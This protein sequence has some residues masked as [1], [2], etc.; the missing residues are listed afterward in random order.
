[1]GKRTMRRDMARDLHHV[2]VPGDLEAIADFLIS[3]RGWTNEAALTTDGGATTSALQ[4]A[5]R[6]MIQDDAPDAVRIAITGF[7]ADGAPV[8]GNAARTAAQRIAE[9][10]IRQEGA[11]RADPR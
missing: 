5:L 11:R 9:S 3:R 4:P 7:T 2:G 10:R 1:M 6:S 8:L